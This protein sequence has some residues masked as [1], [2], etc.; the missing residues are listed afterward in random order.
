MRATLLV[1]LGLVLGIASYQTYQWKLRVDARLQR[2][3]LLYAYLTEEVAKDQNGKP[4]TR[5]QVLD[6]MVQQAL[7]K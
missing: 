5:A 7:K 2:T 3:D 4:L 1:L 6:L